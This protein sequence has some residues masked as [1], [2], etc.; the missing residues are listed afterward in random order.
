MLNKLG[1]FVANHPYFYG[2]LMGFFIGTIVVLNTTCCYKEDNKI[3][4]EQDCFGVHSV[5]EYWKGG[6][7]GEN[8]FVECEFSTDNLYYKF[9]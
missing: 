4:F 9:K 8:Q 3:I 6:Y 5:G 2:S 1:R 7:H